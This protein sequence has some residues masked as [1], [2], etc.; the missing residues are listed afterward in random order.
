M[1]QVGGGKMDPHSNFSYSNANVEDR[2]LEE[3]AMDEQANVIGRARV[4]LD[5]T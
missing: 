5:G 3:D 1:P 4:A 2:F